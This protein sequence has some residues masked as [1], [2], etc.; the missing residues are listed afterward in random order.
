MNSYPLTS[1]LFLLPL[2]VPR[3]I[4]FGGVRLSG[5]IF[6]IGAVVLNCN[7]IV[8]VA[9][10]CHSE[11][12]LAVSFARLRLA[13]G[14]RSDQPGLIACSPPPTPNTPRTFLRRASSTP[15]CVDLEKVAERVM[16]ERQLV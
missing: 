13:S 7:G 5:R 6:W 8:N 9:L 14:N 10:Y 1:I 3:L 2:V 12:W 15:T 4:G 11:R 16:L